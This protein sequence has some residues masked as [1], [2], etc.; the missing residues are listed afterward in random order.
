MKHLFFDETRSSGPNPLLCLI[1]IDENNRK[2]IS[3]VLARPNRNEFGEDAFRILY[4]V[5]GGELKNPE[6]S[7][8][9][10]QRAYYMPV[11]FQDKI[12][13]KICSVLS[14]VRELDFDVFFSLYDLKQAA[15]N[16]ISQTDLKYYYT[17]HLLSYYV[18]KYPQNI[19]RR[20]MVCADYGF[21]KS[22]VLHVV[23]SVFRTDLKTGPKIGVCVEGAPE[24]RYGGKLLDKVVE[25]KSSYACKPIQL[26]D[27]VVG[28]CGRMLYKKENESESFYNYIADKVRILLDNRKHVLSPSGTF[29]RPSAIQKHF[30]KEIRNPDLRKIFCH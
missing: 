18:A 3:E 5:E 9:R 13:E 20:S 21:Y 11:T 2:K 16:D 30:D 22:K 19:L 27:I 1:A 8:R 6:Y 15:D 7:F 10:M 28:I 25:I 12:R 14:A 26:A 24:L 17:T 29:M 23:K 4:C